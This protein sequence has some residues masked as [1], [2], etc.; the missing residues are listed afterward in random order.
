MRVVVSNLGSVFGNGMCSS[1]IV[2]LL[3]HGMMFR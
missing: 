3:H 2:C 1:C